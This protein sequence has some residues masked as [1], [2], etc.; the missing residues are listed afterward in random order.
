MEPQ[1]PTSLDDFLFD[2]RG[3]LVLEQAVAPD[4][5]AE[6]NQAFDRFPDLEP[7]AWWGNAQRRDYTRDTGYEL[8][9]CVEVGAPFERL[10]D[11]PAWISYVRRYCGEADSYV[12]RARSAAAGADPEPA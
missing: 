7:N 12:R 6:L 1:T 10:I 3:Y 2:L 4:L 11:H 5:L 9:N 8:H